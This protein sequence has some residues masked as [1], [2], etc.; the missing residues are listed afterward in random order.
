VINTGRSTTIE[1]AETKPYPFKGWNSLPG[2]GQPATGKRV[3]ESAS[4][5]GRVV[6]MKEPYGKGVASH[7]GPESYAAS[8]EAGGGA[9][10]RARTGWVLSSG[11]RQ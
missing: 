3:L 9:M 6:R 7:P 10:T 11:K 8:R 2:K 5:T 1:C 4:E